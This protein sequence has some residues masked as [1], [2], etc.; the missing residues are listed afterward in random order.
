MTSTLHDSEPS[1][2]HLGLHA[3]QA[4]IATTQA[5]KLNDSFACNVIASM[6]RTGQAVKEMLLELAQTDETII[7][8]YS[9]EKI[10][11]TIEEIRE[12]HT[13][14]TRLNEAV[15]ADVSITLP[16]SD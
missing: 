16:C 3:L 13:E 14:L 6:P 15:E 11:R 7:P 10:Q 1:L 2:S 4:V 8:P 12:H 9:V 5:A